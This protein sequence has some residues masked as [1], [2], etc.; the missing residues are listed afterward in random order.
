MYQERNSD[1]IIRISFI[2]YLYYISVYD[3]L[4]SEGEIGGII[5]KKTL[6]VCIL[7]LLALFAFFLSWHSLWRAFWTA[8]ALASLFIYVKADEMIFHVDTKKYPLVFRFSLCV[9]F[10]FLASF[11]AR[12]NLPDALFINEK[13][14]INFQYVI[15][16]LEKDFADF[17]A[18]TYYGQNE[19][20]RDPC[21]LELRFTY[22]LTGLSTL[23][24][25]ETENDVRYKNLRN[26]RK[27]LIHN[28]EKINVR[29]KKAQRS[30]LRLEPPE[31]S[32]NNLILSDF[33]NKVLLLG[34]QINKNITNPNC[35]IPCAFNHIDSY[36]VQI[37]SEID[38]IRKKQANV[39]KNLTAQ[40]RLYDSL[41]LEQRNRELEL[42]KLGY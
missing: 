21:F 16:T 15:A 8:L 23:N 24:Q 42:V 1:F 13:P 27:L 38:D 18:I 19:I 28:I 5:Y 6:I 25:T 17:K 36:S 37:V 12:A 30:L 22:I 39:S 7:I 20:K 2:T 9:G 26:R 3:T 35:N 14:V 11:G 33:Y 10:F 34:E 40:E 4:S 31:L 32:E 29:E 41:E